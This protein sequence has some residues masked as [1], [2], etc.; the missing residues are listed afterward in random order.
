MSLR[1]T[2]ATGL[3]QV[4][5]VERAQSGE[6]LN[7]FICLCMYNPCKATDVTDPNQK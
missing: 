1:R 2:E 7:R 4:Q 6:E 5:L 3:H